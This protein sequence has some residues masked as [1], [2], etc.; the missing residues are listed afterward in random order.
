MGTSHIILLLFFASPVFL[1]ADR[2]SVEKVAH[3]YHKPVYL[4]APKNQSETLFIV[5]QTGQIQTINN[6][7]KSDPL[8]DIR[9]RVYQPKMP[10]DERGLLGMA[11]HPDFKD[12]GKFYVNYVNRDEMSIISTFT[13]NGQLIAE[14]EEIILCVK[15]PYSNHNGGQVAFG[16][17]GYLYIGLGD[18]GFAGDPESNGQNTHTLLGTILRLDVDGGSPYLIP[19]DNP[20]YN[21]DEARPEIYCYGLRNPWRFSFDREIGDLY[22]GDVGQSSW[23]EINYISFTHSTGSNFGWNQMEGSYCYPPGKDCEQ[24]NLIP[25]IF[26]YAN[27]ANYMKTLIGWDQNDAQGCSVTGGYVYRGS[28]IPELNGKYIFGDYCTGKIWS[29]QVSKGKALDYTKWDIQGIDKDLYLSS[30][31]EDG[32]GELYLLNHTGEIYKI[33]GAK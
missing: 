20:F 31:G 30:F 7:H 11:L 19:T 14:N 5:E 8:L 32:N 25:P 1:L 29:F 9:K 24:D 22:I 2:L 16:P 33:I 28:S 6:G 12:N 10:G 27:N 13:L 18:G 3:G 17:D 26:E 21:H 15:Q 4:T 23:E